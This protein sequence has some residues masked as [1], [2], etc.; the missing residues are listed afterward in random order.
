MPSLYCF[1]VAYNVIK[2]D[3]TMLKDL[4]DLGYEV[5]GHS[6]DVYR[7]PLCTMTSEGTGVYYIEIFFSEKDWNDVDHP[8]YPLKDWI[9]EQKKLKFLQGL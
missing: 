8:E 9:E 1:Q 2:N 6:S 4:H 5:I 7:F 3:A